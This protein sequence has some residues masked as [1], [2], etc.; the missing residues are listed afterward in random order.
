MKSEFLMLAKVYKDQ[1][2]KGW[3]C[4]EKLDGTRA[5]W[6]GG[7]TKGMLAS[8]VPWANTYKDARLKEAPIS[9]GLWSRTGKVVHA[10]EWWTDHLP[11]FF[12]D[13]EM[14][15][16]YGKF[17][18][19]RCEVARQDGDWDSI[20]YKAFGC[21]NANVYEPRMIDVRS[22]YK[23]EVS[24][25][26]GNL[27]PKHLTIGHGFAN[28]ITRLNTFGDNDIFKV[29]KQ[30]A[31]PYRGTD[32]FIEERMDDVLAKGGEGL[33]FRH[34]A[35]PWEACRSKY[36]LKHKP[37]FDTEVVVT[38]FTSGKETDKGS[39]HLGKIGALI[40]EHNDN[41]LKVSGLTDLEREFS[42][43]DE[44]FYA[45]DNPGKDMPSGTSGKQFNVGDVITIKYRELSDDGIPKE[46]RYW[47]KR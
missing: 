20:V 39:K 15:I 35:M 6:D 26:P 19:L 46:A 12:V 3:L 33:M 8:V 25:M 17:Q 4:S 29:V 11:K 10:P 41:R 30:E 42:T 16:G 9:T 1:N 40:T 23:Y 28:E 21:P 43:I 22:D 5:F 38:G 27:T 34:Q 13:G 47:R 24:G 44:K 7:I 36:V 37:W 14:W 31:V 45:Q 18:A 32:E 2:I